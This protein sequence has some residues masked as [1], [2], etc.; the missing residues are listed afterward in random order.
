MTTGTWYN[1]DILIDVDPGEDALSGRICV[2][3]NF[4]Q[5]SDSF[6]ETGTETS[7]YSSIHSDALSDGTSWYCHCQTKDR[8]GNFSS[9]SHL[10]PFWIDRTPPSGDLL[11]ESIS[12]SDNFNVT[13]RGADDLS[14]VVHWNL[15]Y[16]A[17]GDPGYSSLAT[18]LSS[19]PFVF[20]P[21]ASTVGYELAVVF[22]DM[23]GNA[24]ETI[25]PFPARRGENIDV[26]IVEEVE[27]AG[28]GTDYV[29]RAGVKV[30]KND[31]FVGITDASGEIHVTDVFYSDRLTALY[32]IEEMES[33][34]DHHTRGSADPWKWR[35]YI[36]NVQVNDDG[37]LEGYIV[38][39]IRD[40]YTLVLRKT[41]ALIGFNLVV[42][43]EWDAGEDYL[44]HL[45]EGYHLAN[46]YFYA[47]TDG[48][49]IFENIEIHD[50]GHFWEGADIRMYLGDE[51]PRASVN[52]INRAN[53]EKK[54]I[55]PRFFDGS[56][57]HVGPYTDS[58]AYRVIVHEFGHYGFA[59]YDEY[60]LYD[61]ET[62]TE[63]GAHCTD[64]Y[65]DSSSRYYRNT[66]Y[67]ASIMN[68]QYTVS[69]FCDALPANPH[70][71]ATEQHRRRGMSCWEWIE[72]RFR[73]GSSE[74]RWQILRPVDHGD[75]VPGPDRIPSRGWYDCQI[76][77]DADTGACDA[78]FHFEYEDGSP[79]RD[80]G[81][82][83]LTASGLEAFMGST[84][85]NGD[86]MLYG[87]HEGDRALV[88]RYYEGDFLFRLECPSSGG[89]LAGKNRAWSMV[90]SPLKNRV[91]D[92]VNV[93]VQS[94]PY[95]V[96]VGAIPGVTTGTLE[97]TVSTTTTLLEPPLVMVWQEG[98]KFTQ[99]AFC[100]VSW[101]SQTNL[102][103]GSMN[104]EDLPDPEGF[105]LAR[106]TDMEGNESLGSRRF[107]FISPP[108]AGELEW[109]GAE[110]PLGIRMKASSFPGGSMLAFEQTGRPK[111]DSSDLFLVKGP[112]RLFSNT[113]KD[114]AGGACLI[115]S[116]SRDADEAKCTKADELALYKWDEAGNKWIKLNS[117]HIPKWNRVSAPIDSVGIYTLAAPPLRITD[118]K[119]FAMY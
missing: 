69:N 67:A 31:Q 106:T 19:N 71:H 51:W 7:W 97:V 24:S 56:N 82:T 64:N 44:E 84:D 101:N 2:R 94:S 1:R 57:T 42:S 81:V 45:E 59:L 105:V 21:P 88:H 87:V 110:S 18:G 22:E 35:H 8:A 49:M 68:Y 65:N 54:I 96:D 85:R 23:A 3:Y 4:T 38:D 40:P 80:A 62:D 15:S 86:V 36:T 47:G 93:V 90:Q 74:P 9:T 32:L 117:T 92:S 55:L 60:F 66:G 48:Q 73:D 16:R 116:Y 91:A 39:T 13:A 11:I 28:G 72:Q 83:L 37:T 20:V 52:G 76:R 89:K 103:E 118:R 5:Y 104:M 46:D 109:G 6:P 107:R 50:N 27:T 43:L 79:L 63:H 30:Y 99:P 12:G 115:M 34:R 29:E 98:A 25:G 100:P 26:I 61:P 112:Y 53:P 102:Y 111:E 95:R 14:G 70:L 108:E 119:G 75:Q 33:L 114:L 17:V 10:G 113:G 58:D 41:N 78:V 77:H